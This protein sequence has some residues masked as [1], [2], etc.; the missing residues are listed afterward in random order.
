MPK[1]RVNEIELYYEVKGDLDSKKT[2]V[3]LNGVMASVSS[4]AFQVKALEKLGFK[5]VLHDFRGQLLS[6]KPKGPY[7]FMQHAKDVIGLLDALGIQAAHLIGTS[8]GGEVGM[9]CA[10]HYKER[11]SSLSIINSVSETDEVLR[12]F[13]NSWH[14]LAK[15][16]QGKDFFFSMLPSIYHSEYIKSNQELILKRAEAMN[17]IDPSYFD[18]QMY[19]YETFTTDLDITDRLQEITCPVLVVCGEE[20]ILKPRK[21]SDIIATKIKHAEY[22]LIP[23][24]AHVTIFEKPDMLNSM[25][26]GFLI[27]HST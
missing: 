10:V 8:Y 11:V 26:I 2:I 16:K 5:I 25:L 19:L 4:W 14:H 15:A 3:F 6:D 21:F 7:T 18:G 12:Y 20:D 9:Y 1:V 24:C 17:Q 13:V 27:K 23:N 22:A